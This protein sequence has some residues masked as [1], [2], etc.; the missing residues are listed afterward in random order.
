MV[1]GRLLIGA[2][3]FSYP[4]WGKGVFYPKALKSADWLTYYSR[5]FKTVE[6]NNTF[7]RL[8]SKAMLTHWR[9]STPPDFIFAVKASRYITHFQRLRRPEES[10]A[11][12]LARI[13]TLK[14]KL[15]PVLF[16]L[17]PSLP[18]SLD[19]LDDWLDFMTPMVTPLKMRSN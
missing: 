14:E 12:L 7:Y 6:L 5:F 13:S 10:T 8:P 4:H 2:S 11:N 18:V 1:N 3:G 19:L 15:G 17:P 16:Q 9:V